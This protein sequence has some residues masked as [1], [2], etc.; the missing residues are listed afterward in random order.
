MSVH[1]RIQAEMG[2]RVDRAFEDGKRIAIKV[3][4]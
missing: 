2:E 4:G 1:A 3:G